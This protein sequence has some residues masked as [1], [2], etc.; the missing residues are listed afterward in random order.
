MHTRCHWP[1][2]IYQAFTPGSALLCAAFGAIVELTAAGARISRGSATSPQIELL[3]FVAER[4]A[5]DAEQASGLGLVAPS[6]LQRG[7]DQ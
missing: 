7:C 4:V 5:G 6:F 2:T 1:L 3:H